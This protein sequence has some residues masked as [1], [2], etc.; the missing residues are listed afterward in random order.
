M[1]RC[2]HNISFSIVRSEKLRLISEFSPII[3]GIAAGFVQRLIGSRSQSRILPIM[4]LP[5]NYDEGK[6][7]SYSVFTT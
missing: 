6:T 2:W 4:L 1:I 3:K 5:E 7:A